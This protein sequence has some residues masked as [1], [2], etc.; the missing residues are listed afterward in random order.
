MYHECRVCKVCTK[1]VF[2]IELIEVAAEKIRALT[3]NEKAVAEKIRSLEDAGV[4]AATKIQALKEES[5]V[6]S[7]LKI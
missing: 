3:I 6:L 5:K 1:I 2:Y 4:L 7:A